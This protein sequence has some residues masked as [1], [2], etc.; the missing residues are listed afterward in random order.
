MIH[1]E[2]DANGRVF[3]LR[4]GHLLCFAPFFAHQ[5]PCYRQRR[6][7]LALRGACFAPPPYLAHNGW[8]FDVLRIYVVSLQPF[9]SNMCAGGGYLS[10]LLWD[11]ENGL[12]PLGHLN[13][14]LLL[15]CPTLPV[16]IH[17]TSCYLG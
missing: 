14:I 7:C 9:V 15:I 12:G 1:G 10:P 17:V 5:D 2:I 8:S 13:I 6:R 16:K 11:R 4:P 3:F